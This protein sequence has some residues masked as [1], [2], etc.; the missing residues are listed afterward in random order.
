MGYSVMLNNKTPYIE[1][2]QFTQDTAAAVTTAMKNG[3]K[4]M[5]LA[6]EKEIEKA[7]RATQ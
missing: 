4:Q 6:T 1:K 2:I 5:T 7:N 3:L